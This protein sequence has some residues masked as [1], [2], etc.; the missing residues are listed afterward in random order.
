M[1][2]L[3]LVGRR[4]QLVA[5]GTIFVIDFARRGQIFFHAPWEHAAQRRMRVP[6]FVEQL[7]VRRITGLYPESDRA[8]SVQMNWH[9]RR[10]LER[11]GVD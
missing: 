9:F 3:V 11:V 4:F 8:F 7:R 1:G 5:G 2:R 6:W 10:A